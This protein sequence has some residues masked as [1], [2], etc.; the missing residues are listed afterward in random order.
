MARGCGHQSKKQCASFNLKWWKA[1][2]LMRYWP[3]DC[4]IK[5][6]DAVIWTS[7]QYSFSVPCFLSFLAPLFSFSAFTWAARLVLLLFDW[8]PASVFCCFLARAAFAAAFASTGSSLSSF[9]S[10]SLTASFLAFYFSFFFWFLDLLPPS[11]AYYYAAPSLPFLALSAFSFLASMPMPPSSASNS[12]SSSSF[13]CFF[14]FFFSCCL[15][16]FLSS[17]FSSFL[18][19]SSSSSP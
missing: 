8:P 17:A 19:S 3:S 7:T 18:L 13:Y 14:D 2:W 9:S 4:L 5:L 11:A 1:L 10:S 15:S 12:A 6:N 16:S